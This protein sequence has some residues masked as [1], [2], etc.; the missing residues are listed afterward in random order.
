VRARALRAPVFLGSLPRQTGRC[1]P[2]P[3]PSQLRC[4]LF[5]PQKYLHSIELWVL[6][7]IGNMRSPAPA[8]P[9]AALLILPTIF[10]GSTYV[11]MRPYDHTSFGFFLFSIVFGSF[12]FV[13]LFFFSSL[14]YRQIRHSDGFFKGAKPFLIHLGSKLMY[15]YTGATIRPNFL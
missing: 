15:V 6:D 2:P 11:P 7:H 13:I 4:F 9:N 14:H 1:A 10:L 5:D 12:L 8:T 3:G